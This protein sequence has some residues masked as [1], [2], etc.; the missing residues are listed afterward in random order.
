MASFLRS[1]DDCN[2]KCGIPSIDWVMLA[3][4]TCFDGCADFDG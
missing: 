4:G 1:A 3:Q 2:R